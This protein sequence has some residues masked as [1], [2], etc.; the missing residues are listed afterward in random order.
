MPRWAI[1]WWNLNLSIKTIVTGPFQENSYLLIEKLSNKC[2]LIDP[3]DEAKKLLI[4]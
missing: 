3:G 1:F 2:V 4:I